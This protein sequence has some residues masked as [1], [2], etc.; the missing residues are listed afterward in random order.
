MKAK[1]ILALLLLCLCC[2]TPVT[3]FAETIAVEDEPWEDSAFLYAEDSQR[4]PLYPDEGQTPRPR[5]S[6]GRHPSAVQTDDE[7]YTT[8]E[9]AAAAMRAHLNARD[10]AFVLRYRYDSG[11]VM[12][13]SEELKAFSR[14]IFEQSLEHTGVPT[15]GDYLRWHYR[16]YNTVI[17]G[18]KVEEDQYVYSLTLAY[19]MEYW[20]TAEQEAQVTQTLQT[21]LDSMQLKTLTPAEKVRAFYDYLCAN[22][23]YDYS[24]AQEMRYTAYGALI[25]HRCV[26]QGY[27]VLFYR[28]ALENGI[29]ARMVIGLGSRAEHGWDIVCLDGVY[30]NLD[31]TWDAGKSVYDYF[32]KNSTDFLQHTRDAM[33]DTPEFHAA[34]PMAEASFDYDAYLNELMHP[35]KSKIVRLTAK[36]KGFRVQWKR[37]GLR[38]GGYQIQY[39][40]SAKFQSPKTVTIKGEGTD[41]RTITKRKV[42]TRYYV[43]V[44]SYSWAGDERY[45]SAW[46]AAKRVTTKK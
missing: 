41:V 38:S 9:E 15:E 30:Y 2:L 37:R 45:F 46:S 4:N 8:I 23:R 26:C 33:Y 44:R 22:V 7:A 39:S 40:T 10:T 13:T 3:A 36:S 29:D 17:H 11:D 34:Y 14:T 21:V 32:L 27:A 12:P 1:K 5:R 43:R 31:A 35:A 42:R 28:M 24:G 16:N 18:S 6:K 25:D 20:S 19:T